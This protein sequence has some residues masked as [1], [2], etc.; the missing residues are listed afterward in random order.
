MTECDGDKGGVHGGGGELKGTRIRIM[1]RRRAEG[2]GEGGWDSV[3]TFQRSR[4]GCGGD[5]NPSLSKERCLT[6]IISL[7]SRV[8]VGV[9]VDGNI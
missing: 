8:V 2:G 4:C 9:C 7:P 6:A 5:S 3:A 1:R